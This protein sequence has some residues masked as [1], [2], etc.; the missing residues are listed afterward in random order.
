MKKLLL[1]VFA[2][3]CFAGKN[4]AQL[5]FKNSQT[6]IVYVSIAYYDK[7]A[8]HEG[9]W[10]AGW[11]HI[12]PGETKILLDGTL[13]Y[14]EYYYYAY[15]AKSSVWEG[16]GAYNFII[17]TKNAFEIKNADMKY[18]LEKGDNREFRAFRKITVGEHDSY[19]ISLT[20]A[21]E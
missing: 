9:W 10:S 13:K 7:S 12:E 4:F 19:T 17:D 15:D 18:Q 21:E 11:Y 3:F 20:A 14:T 2:L 1:L 5:K 16:D 6:E 8:D